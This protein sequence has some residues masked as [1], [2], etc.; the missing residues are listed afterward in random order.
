M[1]ASRF[2][3][4]TPDRLVNPMVD[5]MPT[6]AWCDD[7]PRIEFPVSLP[8]PTSPRLAATAAAVPPPDPAVPRSSPY[9]FRV[10]PGRME[11]TFSYGLN[12]HSAIFDLANTSA[13]ASLMRFT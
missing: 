4:K 10:Y 8:N 7:G 3:G 9:G 11:F 2:K 6:S 13:P 1:S 12:A 5:R